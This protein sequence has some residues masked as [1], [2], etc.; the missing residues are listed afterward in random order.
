MASARWNALL[1]CSL[2][3]AEQVTSP[4]TRPMLS[5][6]CCSSALSNYLPRSLALMAAVCTPSAAVSNTREDKMV[7]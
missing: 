4:K 1:W 7:N 2:Y 3:F 6:A 5:S